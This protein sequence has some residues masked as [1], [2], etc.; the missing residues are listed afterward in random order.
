MA[1]KRTKVLFKFFSNLFDKEIIETMWALEIDKE[2]GL[3]QIDNIPF[4]ASLVASEDVVFAEYDPKEKMLTYKKT[5]DHSGNS[6]VQVIIV[7]EKTEIKKIRDLFE[8][9]GCKSEQP[10]ESFFSMEVPFDLNYKLVKHQLEYLENEEII[11][12]GEA[13]L[14]EKHRIEVNP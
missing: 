8:K 2:N 5:I 11:G 1:Q 3:Y 7:D 12:Y 13:C 4:Y 10:Q 6:V 9:L 14:S